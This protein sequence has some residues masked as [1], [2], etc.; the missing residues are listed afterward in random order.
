M[1]SYRGRNNDIKKKFP[2]LLQF[3][4]GRR[5]KKKEKK[6]F[7]TE[8]IPGGGVGGSGTSWE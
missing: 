1:D 2:T 8:G 3:L 4:S 7:E 6:T 5:A